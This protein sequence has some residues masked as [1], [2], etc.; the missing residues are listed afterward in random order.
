MG[1]RKAEKINA[2]FSK[3]P[4]KV[5]QCDNTRATKSKLSSSGKIYGGKRRFITLMQSSCKI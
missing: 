5:Q 4:S 3:E 2:L 1:S